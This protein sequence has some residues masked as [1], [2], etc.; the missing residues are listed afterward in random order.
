MPLARPAA[1]V[2]TLL[3]QI[4]EETPDAPALI[5]GDRTFSFVD[6]V[7]AASRVAPPLA[8][9]ERLAAGECASARPG[10]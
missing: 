2:W 6:L 8:V 1:D 5:H 9:Q 4:V 3:S 7:D 10:P